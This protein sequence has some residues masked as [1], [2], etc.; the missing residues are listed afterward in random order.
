[1]RIINHKMKMVRHETPR[2][3]V[4]TISDKLIFKQAE[5][6]VSIFV[7]FEDANATVS[8]RD[9]VVTTRQRN[10]STRSWHIALPSRNPAGTI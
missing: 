1:M 3:N 2:R 5:H 9:Y 10:Y 8:A 6:S 7:I 4:N